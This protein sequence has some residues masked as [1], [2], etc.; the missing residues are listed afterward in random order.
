MFERTTYRKME[1]QSRATFWNT[2]QPVAT[3]SGIRSLTKV[4]P[5]GSCRPT[6]LSPSATTPPGSILPTVPVIPQPDRSH[7]DPPQTYVCSSR[8]P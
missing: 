1:H 6:L 8:S 4:S 5:V 2:T 3:E 7:R